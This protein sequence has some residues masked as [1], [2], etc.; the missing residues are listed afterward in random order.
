MQSEL[1][2]NN[3]NERNKEIM[4]YLFNDTE[5]TVQYHRNKAQ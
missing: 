4:F 1:Q 5:K 2:K 3:E